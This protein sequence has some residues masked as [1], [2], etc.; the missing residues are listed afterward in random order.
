M[1]GN[2]QGVALFAGCNSTQTVQDESYQ[3]IARTLAANNVL[4]LATGCGAGAFAKHGLMNQ[5]A[6]EQYAG[7]SLKAV[8]TQIGEAAGLNGPLPLVLHM[9][10]CVDN[11]RAVTLATALANRLGVD[12]CDLP[13]VASA[14]EAMSEKAIAIASWGVAI[15]LPTHL[16]T[17]P[18]VTGSDVVTELMQEGA[19]DLFG[20]YFL[21]ETDPKIAG[22]KLVEVIKG[23]RQGLGI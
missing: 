2:I 1:N 6:T 20:G 15:G 4:L 8:L 9:G 22:N 17:I 5:Q 21:V 19:K 14:P 23:K 3:I 7:D 18:Q 13:V 16:G 12:L 11:S 10:S